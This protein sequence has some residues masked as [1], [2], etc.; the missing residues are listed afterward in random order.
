MYLWEIPIV[1]TVKVDKTK[2][3]RLRDARPGQ[4]LS[5]VFTGSRF[6]LNLVDPV[7]P[8]PAKVTVSKRGSFSVGVTDRD[9]SD[10]VLEQALS[11][12]P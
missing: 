2:R 12:F 4:I 5:Y 3:V 8:R 6:D 11:E 9:I 7:E 1:H 10:Q